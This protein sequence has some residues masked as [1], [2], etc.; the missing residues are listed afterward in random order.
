MFYI[1][2]GTGIAL[3]LLGM[4][5]IAPQHVD[6]FRNESLARKRHIASVAAMVA[7]YV[8]MAVG[9][10]SWSSP[11][12]RPYTIFFAVLALGYVIWI[13]VKYQRGERRRAAQRR[14]LPLD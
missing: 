14:T 10:I 11:T 13:S 9:A 2:I 8:V 7:G 6:A 1:L 3:F 12:D 5:V 4:L